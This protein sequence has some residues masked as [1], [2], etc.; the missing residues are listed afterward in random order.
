VK[1]DLPGQYAFRNR[2]AMTHEEVESLLHSRGLGKFADAILTAA[3]KCIRF[4]AIPNDYSKGELGDSRLGGDPDLPK[5]INWPYRNERPLQFLAQISLRDLPPIHDELGLPST[6]IL[7]FFYDMVDQPWG[8]D[9]KDAGAARVI[10]SSG[11]LTLERRNSPDAILFEQYSEARVAAIEHLSLSGWESDEIRT[12]DPTDE[13]LNSY[14]DLRSSMSPEYPSTCHQL[15]GWPDEIQG[16]M[17]VECQ[18]VTNG[19]YCGDSSGYEDPRAMKLAQN[20]REWRLLFQLDSD[21]RA[22]MMWGDAGRLYFWIRKHDLTSRYFDS[23][24]VILQCY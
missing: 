5:G 12:L 10:Y 9:P 14:I 15:L 4:N 18:L 23:T 16:P 17:E 20:A 2:T 11:L 3:R 24:W 6:G 22:D 8:Y 13:Q 7:S 21:E 19:L 1:H